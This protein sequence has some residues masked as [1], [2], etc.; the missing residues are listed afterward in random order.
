MIPDSWF[1]EL[2]SKTDIAEIIGQYTT[3]TPKGGKL[4]ACCPFHSEKTPSFIVDTTKQLYYCFGCHKGGNVMTFLKEKENMTGMEAIEYL[5]DRVGMVLPDSGIT[6]GEAERRKQLRMRLYNANRDAARFYFSKLTEGGEGLDYLHKRSL[7]DGVIKRFGLGFSPN[8]RT[9]L[10]EHL[11]SL[12]YTEDEL[13]RANLSRRAEGGS[14]YDNFRNR[15]MFP[16]IDER[17]NVLGF[18]GRTMGDDKPK[19]LNTSD[20][21]IYSKKNSVYALNMLKKGTLSDIIIVEG[22]MDVISLHA[23]GVDNAVATLGTALT[24]NQARLLKR[25]TNVIYVSYDGD[26][27]GQNAT[28]RGLDILA[29]EGLDVRVIVLPDG[30]DP[31]DFAKKY[32]KDGYMRLKDESKTLTAFK[33]EHIAK[34]FDM[35]NPD[36]RQKF[37]IEACKIVAGLQPVEQERYYDMVAQMSGFSYETLQSQGRREAA[38]PEKRNNYTHIANNREK[39]PAFAKNDSERTQL[40]LIRCAVSSQ[41]AAFYIE[42]EG[43]EFIERKELAEFLRRVCDSYRQSG[44]CDVSVILSSME[45]D[46]SAVAA[47]IFEVSAEEPEKTAKECVTKLKREKIQAEIRALGIAYDTKQISA[48]EYRVRFAELSNLLSALR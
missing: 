39:S 10:T 44:K 41:N 30:L 28:M 34:G 23:H 29:N 33:I 14:V 3:L 20:T 47:A 31:D 16:I 1:Y 2:Y 8:K 24:E 15:V 45:E 38:S 18:G 22:Y 7:T 27:A 5:A 21:P 25:R 32:G 43:M 13:V 9:E 40:L 19:Y 26:S 37:A 11:L 35:T 48:E 4:W 6:P 36:E 46:T 17:G 12:G 42:Q